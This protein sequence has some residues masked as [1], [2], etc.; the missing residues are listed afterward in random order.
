[1]SRNK[2]RGK[3]HW[4]YADRKSK[5]NVH[6]RLPKGH[7]DRHRRIVVVPENMHMHFHA[8]FP[9]PSPQQICE[10]LNDVWGN[11]EFIFTAKKIEWPK[12][13]MHEIDLGNVNAHWP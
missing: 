5:T 4:R 3:L 10:L 11:P 13:N 1:M 7:P 8:L 6:H 9:D 2:E 12:K